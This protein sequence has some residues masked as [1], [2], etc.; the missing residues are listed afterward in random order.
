LHFCGWGGLFGGWGE[1]LLP[2]ESAEKE[3]FS[4]ESAC[5]RERS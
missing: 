2:A 4:G 5:A 3:R 1:K